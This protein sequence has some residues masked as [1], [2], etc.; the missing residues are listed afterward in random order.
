MVWFILVAP[1]ADIH[2]QSVAPTHEPRNAEEARLQERFGGKVKPEMYQKW[3]QHMQSRAPAEQDWLRTL[4]SQLGNFY[5]PAYLDT[6]FDPKY[7]PEGDAW[8]Y[9]KDEPKLPRVLIIGDSISRAYTATVRKAL[10]GIAN[11][12]RA[13]A[14]CGPTE[15]FLRDGE[16]W[17][18]QNGR[19]QWDVVIV[20][21]GIHDAKNPTSYEANLRKVLAR[22]KKSEARIFWVRTTPWGKDATVFA[23]DTPRDASELTNPLSDRVVKEFGVDVIDAHALMLPMVPAHLNRKDF[24]HWDA[25]AYEKLGTTVAETVKNKIF[26]KRYAAILFVRIKCN[27]SP[28]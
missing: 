17:L 5:F 27:N 15:K 13:P 20:N 26:P 3:Q 11:V 9:V 8:A 10:K 21:F 1:C 18:N 4:E 19:N 24:T 7:D 25:P 14:N 6:L 16:V 12:H 28:V 23:T 2:A 22:L